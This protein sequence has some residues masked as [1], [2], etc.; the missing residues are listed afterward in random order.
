LNPLRALGLKKRGPSKVAVFDAQL[1]VF[2]V[3]GAK[4]GTSGKFR[5]HTCSAFPAQGLIPSTLTSLK[6][7]V[8]GPKTLKVFLLQRRD[9]EINQVEKPQMKDEELE[10][11]LRWALTSVVEYSAAEA[12]L[13]WIDIP[14]D[15]SQ[16][17][18]P[19]QVYLVSSQ[20]KLV[21]QKVDLFQQGGLKLDAVDIRET[22]QR[23]LASLFEKPGQ[24]VLLVFVESTGLQITVSFNGNLFLERFI[25]EQ[26]FDK[27][28][29]L[30]EAQLDRIALEIQRSL[31]FVR[32]VYPFIRL[33]EVLIA[34]TAEPIQLAEKLSGRLQEQ[35][36]SVNL[37]QV[38]DWP[39][40]QGLEQ[41]E[42]QA[43][44]FFALGAA[45][46]QS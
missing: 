23:N 18:K 37:S 10:Q 7:Q 22:S 46:R 3:V 35:V 9:Y 44:Y 4:P 39:L 27:N 21:D 14:Q 26:L 43:P 25:P 17:G 41:P 31:D 5:V 38:F 32:R 24:G 20:K 45:V 2:C 19:A 36:Q 6:A 33:E 16:A 34:P 28:S 12:N 13:D 8:D 40:G 30:D 15:Q 11:S 1:G 42:K 29:A